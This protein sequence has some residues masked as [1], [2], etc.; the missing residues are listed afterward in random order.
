VS[1]PQYIPHFF[2]YDNSKDVKRLQKIPII[3]ISCG[4]YHSIAIDNRNQLYC[5]GEARYGQTATGKKTKE[6]IPTKVAI[7]FQVIILLRRVKQE[8]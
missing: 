1:S 7:D 6:P 4:S 3:S 2:K 5:W 8:K